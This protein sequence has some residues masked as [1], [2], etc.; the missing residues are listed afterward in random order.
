MSM[1]IAAVVLAAGKGTR[2]GSDLHKVL[3]PL[4]GRPLLG[5]LLDTLDTL[6]AAKRVVVVGA[7]RDQIAHAFPGLTTA[8]QE[9]QLGTAHA[10]RMAETT[11]ADFNGTV[12][13][14][15]GDVP[16]VKTTTMRR[17]CVAVDSDHGLAVLG[18]HPQDT[19]TY[20][21]LVTNADAGLEAIVEH[22]DATTA[23][24]EI[25]FCNSGIMAVRSDLLWPLLVAVGNDNRKG[26]YYLTDIVH[27]AR[28]Q[29]HRIATTESSE[30][31]VTGVNSQTELQAL[32]QK[33]AE[34]VA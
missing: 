24:R 4:A 28:T 5:H 33:L 30:D 11:L 27:L 7:G 18:F 8:V 22:A 13:V 20:G 26:E 29:G 19:R 32:E 17:L 9:P 34:A 25:G 21:R 23:Q 3:H 14:L 12:L 6:G 1:P 15:Y 16:L 31:E 10:V 2:M